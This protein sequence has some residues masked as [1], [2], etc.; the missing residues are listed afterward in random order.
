MRDFSNTVRSCSGALLVLLLFAAP[1]AASVDLAD[2]A[3]RAIQK[4]AKSGDGVEIA[5]YSLGEGPTVL[6]L[7]GFPDLWLTWTHQMGAL[8]DSYRVVAMDLRG[9]NRSG[10]PEEVSSYEMDH[11]LADV[12][13][14]ID[15]LGEESITLVGHD[16][17]GGIAWRF[18]MAHPEK[19]H[20]LVICN[21]THPRGYETVRINATPEQKANMQYIE[22]I[23]DPEAV[24]KLGITPERLALRWQSNP[25]MHELYLEGYRRS[26]FDGMM[27]YYR[28][29]DMFAATEPGDYP[30]LPMPVLQFHGLK[31]TAVHHDGLRDTWNWIESDY[32]L[33]TLPGIGHNVQ[34]E[35]AETVSQTLRLW[36]DA[37][38]D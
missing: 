18:A 7:H 33:V 5:Y 8:A 25:D 16:W 1:L 34:N 11:L 36:L 2:V 13:A 27:H 17:G 29:A 4:T 26:F 10:Q 31:D 15:D 35:A 3:S 28:A 38:R 22:R 30:Q 6:F 12:N 14:V 37:R 23:R 24:S 20:Q 19:V 32:T 9:Y 21:L